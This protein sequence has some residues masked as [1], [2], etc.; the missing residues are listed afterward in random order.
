MPVCCY[1]SINIW[2]FLR[3]ST[4]A[5]PV[6]INAPI[7]PCIRET[8][9]GQ[10]LQPQLGMLHAL[11]SHRS[12]ATNQLHIHA[13]K[14]VLAVPLQQVTAMQHAGE[15]FVTDMLT[16]HGRCTSML[17]QQSGAALR[18]FRQTRTNSTR[19]RNGCTQLRNGSSEVA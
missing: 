7:S 11:L 15:H 12:A 9:T 17:K 16:A 10:Q 19:P 6:N 13:G 14:I 18:L 8:I 4:A 1:E 3:Y 2:L 5:L